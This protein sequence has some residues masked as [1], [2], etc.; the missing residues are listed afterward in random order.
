MREFLSDHLTATRDALK[1]HV[2]GGK[3]FSADE[4]IGLV[5]RF[6]ELVAMARAQ[7]NE[8]S[9]HRW[10]E[11]ARQEATIAQAANVVAFPRAGTPRHPSGGGTAA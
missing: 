11:A 5:K 6:D 10:N 1:R 4:M 7:E 3:R 8:V 9:R 2:H